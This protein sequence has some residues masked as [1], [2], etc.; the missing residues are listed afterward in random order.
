[1]VT[2]EEVTLIHAP[3]ERCFDLARSVEVHLAGNFHYGENAVAEAGATSGLVGPGDHVTWRARHFWISWTLTSQITAFERPAHFQD[4]M[5]HG[6]F[7]LMRH[8]HRF[9]PTPDGA[10]EMRDAFCFAAPLPVLGRVAEVVFLR[11]YM[12]RLLHER[13]AA[14]KEI[15][16][17]E[18]WR[19]YLAP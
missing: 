17:S 3:V 13:N 10:T 15:A 18:E 12:R 11:A 7:R 6:P 19:R 1:M 4:V 2:L 9:R 14:I 8:D 5:L 16:E